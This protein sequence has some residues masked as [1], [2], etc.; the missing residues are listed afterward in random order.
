MI[1]RIVSAV[2]K[3]I[4]DT[5]VKRRRS[6]EAR[7]MNPKTADVNTVALVSRGNVRDLNRCFIFVI[8]GSITR[9]MTVAASTYWKICGKILSR[10]YTPVFFSVNNSVT[11]TRMTANTAAAMIVAIAY[12][13]SHDLLI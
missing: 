6:D 8:H 1:A 9:I 4:C 7:N 2:S 12:N 10:T 3:R 11:T 13:R 5:I